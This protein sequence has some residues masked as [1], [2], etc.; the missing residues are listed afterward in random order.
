MKSFAENARNNIRSLSPTAHYIFLKFI[1]LTHINPTFGFHRCHTCIRPQ[2]E[3]DT[4]METKR[5]FQLL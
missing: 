5:T 4:T 2:A 1:K 3:D